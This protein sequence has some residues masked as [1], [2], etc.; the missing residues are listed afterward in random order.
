MDEVKKYLVIVKL[1]DGT[2]DKQPREYSWSGW[3]NDLKDDRIQFI[4]IENIFYNKKCIKSIQIINNP[5]YIE[6]ELDS[7]VEEK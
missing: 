2:E 5:D 3:D 6:E 7:N 1:T 4:K